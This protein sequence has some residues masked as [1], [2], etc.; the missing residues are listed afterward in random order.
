MAKT[1]SS[2]GNV[3]TYTPPTGGGAQ[4]SSGTGVSR[5]TFTEE[6]VPIPD[7]DPAPETPDLDWEFGSIVD[8]AGGD[9]ALFD[10]YNGV[11]IESFRGVEVIT[12]GMTRNKEYDG[13]RVVNTEIHAPRV[14]VT[15]AAS[16]GAGITGSHKYRTRY[17]NSKTG[18]VSGFS[19]ISALVEPSTEQVDVSAMEKSGDD[20]V[21]YIQLFRT[22]SGDYSAYYFH[23]Q[24]ANT[25]TPAVADTSADRS[26][27]PPELVATTA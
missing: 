22:L 9:D 14:T 16:G 13:A 3:A 23:S 6:T 2:K 17:L 25:G 11:H 12:D 5:L 24:V 8:D 26:L 21:D 7:P 19:P 15:V 10:P 4:F 20:Q 27:S 18:K 1:F